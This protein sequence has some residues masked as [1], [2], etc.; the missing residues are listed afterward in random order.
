MCRIISQVKRK[1]SNKLRQFK[2]LFLTT[3]E[4]FE[5]NAIQKTKFLNISKQYH[6]GQEGTLEK[7][8]HPMSR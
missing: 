1:K 5:G 4:T 6:N 7:Q 2:I 3:V 8:T